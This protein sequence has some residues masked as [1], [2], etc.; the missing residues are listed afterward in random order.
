MK[1]KNVSLKLSGALLLVS[2]S[3]EMKCKPVIWESVGIGKRV[4]VFGK[5]KAVKRLINHAL[6]HLMIKTAPVSH[7]A[8]QKSALKLNRG[9]KTLAIA[10][11]INTLIN[12]LSLNLLYLTIL[13]L[14]FASA[15]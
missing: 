13:I 6:I 10:S 1:L 9:I 2:A 3:A 11:A 7:L 12:A 15:K 14:K 4:N 8:S 5:K